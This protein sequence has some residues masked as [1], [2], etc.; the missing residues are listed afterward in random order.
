LPAAFAFAARHDAKMPKAA[1]SRVIR[2]KPKRGSI[3]CE[4]LVCADEVIE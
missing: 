3:G 4:E 1:K 2:A